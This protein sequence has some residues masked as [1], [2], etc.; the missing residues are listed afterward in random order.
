MSNFNNINGG[1]FVPVD[2][3]GSKRSIKT[4]TVYSLVSADYSQQE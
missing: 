1:D 3:V 2:V 4:R